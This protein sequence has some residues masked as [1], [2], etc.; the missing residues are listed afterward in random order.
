M[1]FQAHL[2]PQLFTEVVVT[3]KDGTFQAEGTLF[4]YNGCELVL[5]DTLVKKHY[6]EKRGAQYLISVIGEEMN[7]EKSPIVLKVIKDIR[8]FQEAQKVYILETENNEQ[9][10]ISII[11]RKKTMV[12]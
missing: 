12:S 11:D 7:L 6:V 2:Y 8:D 10:E 9:Y 5:V 4:N 1:S 3:K